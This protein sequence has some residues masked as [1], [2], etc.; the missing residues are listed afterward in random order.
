MRGG[1]G[2]VIRGTTTSDDEGRQRMLVRGG[3]GGRGAR[4]RG[5]GATRSKTRRRRGK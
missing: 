4:V 2:L 5:G 1:R 3:P